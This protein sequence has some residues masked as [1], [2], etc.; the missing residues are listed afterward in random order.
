MM[1]RLEHLTKSHSEFS[2]RAASAEHDQM[3]LSGLVLAGA[4]TWLRRG[5]PAPGAGDG[6][7]TAHDISALDLRGT[8]LVVLSCCESARGVTQRQAGVYGL[9]RAFV[10]AGAQDLVL[11]L[12]RVDD[13]YTAKLMIEFYDLIA[14]GIATADALRRAKLQIRKANP[15]PYYWAAFTCQVRRP[16]IRA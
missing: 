1:R 16:T 4:N 5:A 7:V 8:R 15:D 13:N 9:R 6:H 3:T 2:S 14:Q 12:W 10:L 11:S